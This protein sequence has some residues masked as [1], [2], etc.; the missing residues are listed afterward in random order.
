LPQ[1]HHLLL[2]NTPITQAVEYQD[3]YL[4]KRGL[5]VRYAPAPVITGNDLRA[6]RPSVI[7]MYDV[8]VADLEQPRVCTDIA[9]AIYYAH[10]RRDAGV[11][12]TVVL[13]ADAFPPYVHLGL[14]KEAFK[15]PVPSGNKPVVAMLAGDPQTFDFEL[16]AA[17]LRRVGR[18]FS[19]IVPGF[20]NVSEEFDSAVREARK[21]QNVLICPHVVTATLH[22]Y[23]QMQFLVSMNCFRIDAEAGSLQRPVIEKP[24]SAE[25]LATTLEQMVKDRQFREEI[26][27]RSRTVAASRDLNLH[28]YEFNNLVRRL[29]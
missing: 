17:S 18:Q 21:T 28:L 8:G 29:L 26:I 2:T 13:G 19:F 15:R 5:D 22:A 12:S 27:D 10:Y 23:R 16:A 24:E 6:C 20:P 11:A 4:A 1:Y 9:P 3:Q 7:I 14:V 25:Q